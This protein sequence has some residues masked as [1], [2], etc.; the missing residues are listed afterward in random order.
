MSDMLL[1]LSL[2]RINANYKELIRYKAYDFPALIK[3]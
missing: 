3:D 1:T 2:K